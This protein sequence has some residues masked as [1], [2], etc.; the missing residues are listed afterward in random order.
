MMLWAPAALVM[1]MG[2]ATMHVMTQLV[3][4]RARDLSAPTATLLAFTLRYAL[5][6]ATGALVHAALGSGMTL[7]EL[8]MIPWMAACCEAVTAVAAGLLTVVG[9]QRQGRR[10]AH[11]E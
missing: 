7:G 6:A 4:S 8:L 10:S 9:G 3:V 5:S 2:L 11:L 1:L